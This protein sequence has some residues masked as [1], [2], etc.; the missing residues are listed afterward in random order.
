MVEKTKR[1]LAILQHRPVTSQNSEPTSSDFMSASSSA[2]GSS[3][4]L[5]RLPPEGA[6]QNDIKKTA[7]EIMAQTIKATEDRVAEVRR[8]AGASLSK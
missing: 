5:R 6:E 8:R 3:L 7:G 1:A 4:W 2:G